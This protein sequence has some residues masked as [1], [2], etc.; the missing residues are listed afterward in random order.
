MKLLLGKSL[1]FFYLE[2]WPIYCNLLKVNH[3]SDKPASFL[4]DC[5]AN[6]RAFTKVKEV[7]RDGSPVAT[8]DLYYL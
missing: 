5:R 7:H 8:I 3:S 2:F 6:L 4:A 1:L